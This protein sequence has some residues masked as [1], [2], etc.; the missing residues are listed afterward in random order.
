M[1]PADLLGYAASATVLGTFCM[2]T[3]VPLRLLAIVS[4]VLFASY[5]GISRIYPVLILHVV[6]LPINIY[7]LVQGRPPHSSPIA[8]AQ[9]RSHQLAVLPAA[10]S[11]RVVSGVR[12]IAPPCPKRLKARFC[13]RAI[14][15]IAAS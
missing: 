13:P 9:G 6:L 12:S 14:G 10:R 1:N 8:P 2:S 15:A 7:R 5:G 11:V 3:M 4:N